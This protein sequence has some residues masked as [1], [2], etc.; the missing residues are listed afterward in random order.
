MKLI[1]IIS[2]RRK[3]VTPKS[4]HQNYIRD[5]NLPTSIRRGV[6]RNPKSL[7][8][9]RKTHPK[10]VS[11]FILFSDLTARVYTM[12]HLIFG[13]VSDFSSQCFGYHISD[14]RKAF[15]TYYDASPKKLIC[16]PYL[17]IWTIMLPQKHYLSLFITICKICHTFAQTLKIWVTQ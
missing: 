7:S 5:T 11:D 15:R 6:I 8:E 2:L 9:I 16:N 17:M 13:N 12:L 4:S 3:N 10:A 14:I 1:Y